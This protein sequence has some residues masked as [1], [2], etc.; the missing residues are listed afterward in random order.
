MRPIVILLLLAL[1]ACGA[2]G[3]LKPEKG[4]PLPVA[5]YGATATPTPEQLLSS[6]PQARPERSDE[7]LKNSDERG[8]NDFDLPPPNR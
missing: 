3:P 1:S 2:R 4:T 8:R 6:S 7:L 5:P